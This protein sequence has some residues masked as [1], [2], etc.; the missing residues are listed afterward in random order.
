MKKILT[1][2][3]I[4]FS[5][6]LVG[7]QNVGIGTPS[8]AARLHVSDSSV[9]FSAEVALI[10]PG[11]PPQ[12][13]A[14]GRM[15][16]YADK[17]AFRSGY[18]HNNWDKDSVGNYSFATGFNTKAKGQFSTSFGM[19]AFAEVEG[20][21]SAGLFTRSTGNYAAS[22]GNS[23]V[24]SGYLSFASGDSSLA[25]AWNSATFG[26]FNDATDNP[27]FYLPSINDRIFQVG[28]GS[29]GNRSN[30]LT[31]L[32]NGMSGIGTVT[33]RYPL[34]FGNENGDRISLFD[35][36]NGANAHFGL[37]VTYGQLLQIHSA[38]AFDDIA[39]GT[40]NSNSF[41][42]RMRI[43]GNGKVGINTN[44]PKA[45]FHVADSSVL[46]TG[47]SFVPLTT[48]FGPPVEGAG[49]RMM[50]YPEKG[51]FRA[52]EVSGTEW[53]MINI[54]RHSFVAGR[55]S[56]AQGQSAVAIGFVNIAN[57]DYSLALGSGATASGPASVAIGSGVRSSGFASTVTGYATIARSDFSLV[58]G[59]YNDTTATNRLFEIGNGNNDAFRRNALT[60]LTNNNT[61]IGTALPVARLHVADSSVLFSVNNLLPVSPGHPPVSGSGN[62]MFWYADK[63]A[64]RA[65][66]VSGTL[67]DRDNIGAQ[68]FAAGFSTQALG[69]TSTAFGNFAFANGDMSFAAGNS[70]FAKARMAASFGTFND[71]SDSPN[72]SSEAASDRLFQVGN[73]SSNAARANA[74]TILRNGNMGLS[75][76]VNPTR[77]LSFPAILGEK[78]LLYPG[79]TGEVGIGVYGNELR[80]HCDNPGS[81]V[82][83]GTQ[84]NAGVFTQAGRF[85]LSGGF[86]LYVNGNIWANGTTY[87]SDA[88]FKTDITPIG[89]PLQK[90]L[91]IEGV[92]Y[93]MKSTEF[94][95][96]NFSD[97]R[98]MGLLA[99]N[100]E[101]IVPEAVN[102][103]DGYKGVDYARLVPLLIESIKE[104]QKQIDELKAIIQKIQPQH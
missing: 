31:I 21:F 95:K 86:G 65:G 16:W 15:M 56:I 69:I 103:L 13:G 36:G 81:M 96:N 25:R 44:N 88:R 75:G 32:R 53:D 70:V 101:K 82:S 18:T 35:D 26:A 91:Q 10:T 20:A 85:Q 79:G 1:A 48:S 8:P 92:E 71:I 89:S 104:Q 98:Q 29:A 52:G 58:T 49:T 93:K 55:S 24:A 66:G 73:G 42:E 46:F 61:G 22:F 50:W 38:T 63:A 9:L 30:A 54:G 80:L 97:Q 37:G 87:A 12:S 33:P 3:F 74:L 102:E 59:K 90:L 62:R 23:S 68:S 41:I 78:I 76:V 28:N 7:A 84:D 27:V 39:F 14:G 51:A 47:P 17:L 64:F 83:F 94:V 19:M 99:Q 11:L 40:G 2:G 77:P 72:P 45:F 34:S 6:S 60:V 5:S 4:V 67:W 100:V 43:K 57:G